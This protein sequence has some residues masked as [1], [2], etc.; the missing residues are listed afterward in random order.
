MKREKKE[1]EIGGLGDES[2]PTFL[3][4]KTKRRGRKKGKKEDES[5]TGEEEKVKVNE[6]WKKQEESESESEGKIM[7][8]KIL[9][10]SLIVSRN[11][12]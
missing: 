5:K 1:K 6:R 8:R 10:L 4:K 7:E 3:S 9:Q 12:R 2:R 11:P